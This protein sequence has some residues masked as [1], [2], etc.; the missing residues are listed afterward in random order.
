MDPPAR[1]ILLTLKK[2]TRW[3]GGFGACQVPD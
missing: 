1:I 3:E 2:K